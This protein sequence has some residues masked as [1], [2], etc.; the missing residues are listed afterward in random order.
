MNRR[1]LS[2]GQ[3]FCPEAPGTTCLEAPY[4]ADIKKRDRKM[5]IHTHRSDTRTLSADRLQQLDAYHYRVVCV[6]S[7]DPLFF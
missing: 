7:S 1:C 6:N 5:Y 2:A 3:G 4:Q